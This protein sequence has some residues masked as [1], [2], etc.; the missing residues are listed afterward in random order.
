MLVKN[1]PIKLC[2]E[3][4]QPFN[5]KIEI[6]ISIYANNFG[7]L[8]DSVFRILNILALLHSKDKKFLTFRCEKEYIF[9]FD[10][11]CTKG[12]V[13]QFHF[14]RRN[15]SKQQQQQH[16]QHPILIF[17]DFLKQHQRLFK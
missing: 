3:T 2:K 9:L 8:R 17:L 14:K 16:Q 13:N 12:Q 5:S 7:H 15:F 6:K 10:K 1:D 11:V 4:E